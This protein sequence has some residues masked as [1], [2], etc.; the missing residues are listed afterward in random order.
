M[1]SCSL[2][3]LTSCCNQGSRCLLSLISASHYHLEDIF[4]TTVNTNGDP[5]LKALLSHISVFPVHEITKGV[6][7]AR[8][9][10]ATQYHDPA[11]DCRYICRHHLLIRLLYQ[12]PSQE[13]SLPR[14]TGGC[15]YYINCFACPTCPSLQSAL[16]SNIFVVSDEIHRHGPDYGYLVCVQVS[17][18]M[19]SRTPLALAVRSR[20]DPEPSSLVRALA[21]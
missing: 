5:S 21:A 9:F 19:P 18:V 3:I 10:G 8:L 4:P 14:P 6:L 16:V 11:D 7:F 1:A 15:L 17:A 20:A 2:F 13:Q 12:N